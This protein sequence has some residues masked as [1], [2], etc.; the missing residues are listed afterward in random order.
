MNKYVKHTQSFFHDLQIKTNKYVY[1][2]NGSVCLC[3]Y[4]LYIGTLHT[5][6]HVYVFQKLTHLPVYNRNL[7]APTK[8][9][10]I[11]AFPYEIDRVFRLAVS[12][13][14]EIFTTS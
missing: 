7:I 5:H 11:S 8:I 4:Y 9:K 1:S 6:T 2:Q 14:D 12:D 10:Y 13:L 3:Q